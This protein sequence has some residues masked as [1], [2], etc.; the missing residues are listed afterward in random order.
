VVKCVRVLHKHAC[1]CVYALHM[2]VCVYA[3]N[4]YT[5]VCE[6]HIYIYI[7][8][9]LLA[10]CDTLFLQG[11]FQEALAAYNGVLSSSF[12]GQKAAVESMEKNRDICLVLDA[13]QRQVWSGV[14]VC[15]CV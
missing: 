10:A 14:C 2:Y 7:C 13:V 11:R 1:V 3:C 8:V 6:R 9:R 5:C 15:V 12:V 4:S